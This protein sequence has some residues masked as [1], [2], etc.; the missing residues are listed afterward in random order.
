MNHSSGRIVVGVDG[1]DASL[2]AL[3]WALRQAELTSCD[4]EAVTS[5]QQPIGY[6]AD[7]AAESENW[8]VL[9]KTNLDEALAKV[10]AE[11][12]EVKRTVSQ[13]HPAE[14]L[15]NASTNADLIVVGS[16]GHGGFAGMLLGSVRRHVSAHAHCPVLVVRHLD[17]E[18]SASR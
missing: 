14:V 6:G 3:R 5:W 8:E 4:V 9:A 17:A 11:G 15:T 12:V 7:F 2:D 13:G 1:S 16:R 10:D 18:P